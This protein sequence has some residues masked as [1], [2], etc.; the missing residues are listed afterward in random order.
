[1]TSFALIV[2]HQTLPGK[3]DEVREVWEKHMAPAIA[4]NPGHTAYF[5]CF[6]NAGEPEYFIGS[7]DWR[8]RNLSKRV[9]VI[10]PVRAEEHRATLDRILD[11]VLNDP[12]AW[13]LRPDG[14]YVRGE[15]VVPAVTT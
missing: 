8:P 9:E 5:Y 2:K 12:D 14:S 15:E 7:A 6:D 13:T 3:R 11:D 1:M 4:G 10:T